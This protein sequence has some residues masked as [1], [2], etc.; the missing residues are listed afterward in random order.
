MKRISNNQNLSLPI[1][2]SPF[3]FVNSNVVISVDQVGIDK[4]EVDKVKI[5]G[6]KWI[7]WELTKRNDTTLRASDKACNS[8]AVK[9]EEFVHCNG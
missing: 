3:H 8:H 1:I 5:D 9:S 7:K 2:L 4:V 6:L